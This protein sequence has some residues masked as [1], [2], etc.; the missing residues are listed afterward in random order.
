MIRA[1]SYLAYFDDF[2]EIEFGMF[3]CQHAGCKNSTDG[4]Y[5][6]FRKEGRTIKIIPTRENDIY[7][8]T[9]RIGEVLL[10]QI[11]MYNEFMKEASK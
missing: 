10:H 11:Q 2:N 3:L 9:K 8:C 1:I 4:L 7:L 5:Y 6:Y